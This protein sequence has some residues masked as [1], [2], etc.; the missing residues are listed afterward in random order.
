MIALAKTSPG[1]L[2]YGSGGSGSSTHLATELFKS[3]SGI[4]IVR[5]PYKG[6]GQALSD[7]IA[8]QV[9]VI[10][11]NTGAAMVHVRSGRLRALAVGSAEPSPLAPGLP[12][13]AA[14]GVPGYEATAMSGMFVPKR[15]P[16]AIVER[17]NREIVRILD[18][19]DVREK[20]FTA[21]AEAVGDAPLQFAAKI[22]G[23]MQRMGNMI[24]AAGIHE[25]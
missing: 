8:G 9:Q 13:V 20:F 2:N 23:E 5:I 7:A 16:A 18:Q 10:M 4:N 6:V 25:E 17:L 11:P 22:R 21:G 12:T 1:R 14:S 24:K 3:M 19:P 15:T